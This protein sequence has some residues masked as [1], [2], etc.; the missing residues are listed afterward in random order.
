MIDHG[1]LH[2]WLLLLLGHGWPHAP[3]GHVRSWGW[4]PAHRWGWT[5]GPWSGTSLLLRVPLKDHVVIGSVCARHLLLLLLLLWVWLHRDS[6]VIGHIHGAAAS[7]HHAV[8]PASPGLD[9]GNRKLPDASPGFQHGV[10]FLVLLRMMFPGRPHD[11]L[12]M[13]R[14]GIILQGPAVIAISVG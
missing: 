13:L 11:L 6:V 7:V 14:S 12:V 3:A 1:F 5:H 2:P 4:T 9:N 10:Q 8:I